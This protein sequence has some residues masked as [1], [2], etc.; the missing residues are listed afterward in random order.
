M[1]QGWLPTLQYVSI[2]L[3]IIIYFQKENFSLAIY[4]LHVYHFSFDY[5]ST[6]GYLLLLFGISSLMTS[7][8]FSFF[9]AYLPLHCYQSL[10]AKLSS[11]KIKVGQMQYEKQRKENKL[12]ALKVGFSQGFCLLPSD[13]GFWPC[14]CVFSFFLFLHIS[15]QD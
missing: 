9:L 3:Q 10:M 7:L 6:L 5:M 12:Q 1:S 13:M 8:F 15:S 11:L 2:I 14:F 4:S